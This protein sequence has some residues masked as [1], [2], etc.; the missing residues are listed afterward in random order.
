MHIYAQIRKARS[1][2][3]AVLS[4]SLSNGGA[5]RMPRLQ[6]GFIWNVNALTLDHIANESY[7]K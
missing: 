7:G 2:G 4:A 1:P 5:S 3:R 6:I